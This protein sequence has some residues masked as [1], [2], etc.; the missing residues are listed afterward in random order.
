[1]KKT[2]WL[3][4][5]TL[6]AV[7]ACNTS[8]QKVTKPQ[9]TKPKPAVNTETDN[10]DTLITAGD[11]AHILM[12]QVYSHAFSDP[13]K[14]DT[15]KLYLTGTALIGGKVLFAVVAHSGKL[16]YI[17]KFNAYDLIGD[18]DDT[19]PTPNQREDTIRARF[20]DFFNRKSFETPALD[21]S[22]PIDSDLADIGIQ[23]DIRSDKTSIGFTYAYGYEGVQEIAWSKRRKKV[24]I[25]MAA[26]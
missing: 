15:F 5:L 12:R 11:T 6:I 10:T 4:L 22:Q 25:C 16:I 26:D 7:I 17:E 18:L 14:K 19:D 20:N 8:S 2:N 3:Y 23:K 1:M 24:V 9:L 21:I 13:S